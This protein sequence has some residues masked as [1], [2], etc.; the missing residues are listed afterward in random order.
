MQI[1][2]EIEMNDKISHNNEIVGEIEYQY[3]P[4]STILYI[5]EIAIY[6]KNKRK[7]FGER[8]L[9]NLFS[10]YPNLRYIV[11]ISTNNAIPFWKKIGSK[12]GEVKENSDCFFTLEKHSLFVY[13]RR[14]YENG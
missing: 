1:N 10:T 6:G 2:M 8:K 4:K 5:D 9:W 14:K 12:L 11:G 13:L 7:G 3:I